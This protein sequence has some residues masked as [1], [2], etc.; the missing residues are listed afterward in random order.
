MKLDFSSIPLELSGYSKRPLTILTPDSKAALCAIFEIA[1][2]ETGDPITRRRWQQIQ[3][4]NLLHHAIQRST[5]WKK[6]IDAGKLSDIELGTLPVLTR[7]DI[8][9]QFVEGALLRDADGIVTKQHATSGSTGKPAQFFVSSINEQYNT[10]RTTAQYFMEGRDLSLNRTRIRPAD[11]PI[12]GGLSVKKDD[13]YMGMLA[14]LVKSGANK[15]IEY[16]NP[17]LSTLIDELKKDD[18]GYLVCAPRLVESMFSLTEPE[19]LKAANTKMWVSL[20]QSVSP[21]MTAIFDDL[22]I[23]IRATYS[24]EEVG[25]IGYECV[26]CTGHYH[27]ATSN[28]IVEVVDQAYD[29]EGAK[30]GRVLVTHLHSYATPFIRYDIGDLACLSDNCPCGHKG[31]TIHHLHGKVGS[32]VKHRDGRVSPF[33]IRDRELTS[34]VEFKEYRIR[35][36]GFEKLVVEIGGRSELADAEIS[37]V[38]KF[39]RDR[40]G[41]EFEVEMKA[42][43]EIDWGANRKKDGFKCEVDA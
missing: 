2:L 37:A 34:L 18:I 12:K 17:D 15:H 42:C 5:F 24:T 7:E 26:E 13:S 27:I 19:F 40:V 43:Q 33:R 36:T 9:N 8:H 16:Y 28:V 4:G 39:L 32:I 11:G 38:T 21:E 25:P 20:A 29:I 35:Q 6:R 31:P 10:A 30:L 1:L 14:S 23:P 41:Q 22:G 3:L